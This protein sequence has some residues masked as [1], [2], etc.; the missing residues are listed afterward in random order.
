VVIR[1]NDL[2]MR[3]KRTRYR[4]AI[5]A[6]VADAD[7]RS[8]LRQLVGSTHAAVTSNY[9][10]LNC[11]VVAR[12]SRDLPTVRPKQRGLTDVIL[13]YLVSSLGCLGHQRDSA[14]SHRLG[15]LVRSGRSAAR[16]PT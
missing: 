12:D 8:R 16:C 6:L 4:R 14:V 13:P 3:S 11:L 2:L 5:A 1:S 7:T 15:A 9:A 10:G